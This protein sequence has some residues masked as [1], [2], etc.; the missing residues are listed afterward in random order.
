MLPLLVML[1]VLFQSVR[2][3]VWFDSA[4]VRWW[5]W[6][7]PFTISSVCQMVLVKVCDILRY[8]WLMCCAV[9]DS[10][11]VIG[12]WHLVGE[13]WLA[14]VLYSGTGCWQWLVRH[15]R[16]ME[17]PTYL[18]KAMCT[19][20]TEPSLRSG[21]VRFHVAPL[22]FFLW[23]FPWAVFVPFLFTDL[24]ENISAFVGT[25]IMSYIYWGQHQS[26]L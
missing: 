25:Y 9:G 5:G 6:L 2:T 16:R 3:N 20:A 10:M 18:W 4:T 22:H 17:F 12:L 8:D 24:T 13:I 14:D 19:Y 1:A 21:S 7:F 26:P 23:C 15:W 11:I